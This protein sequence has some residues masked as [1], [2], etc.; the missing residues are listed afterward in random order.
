MEP[1]GEPLLLFKGSL[2]TGAQHLHPPGARACR[3]SIR[4][5]RGLFV[6]DNLLQPGPLHPSVVSLRNSLAGAA[7]KAQ[8]SIVL[9]TKASRWVLQGAPHPPPPPRVHPALPPTGASQ[10]AAAWAGLQ[11]LPCGVG[12]QGCGW[13]AAVWKLNLTPE[14]HSLRPCFPSH[15]PAYWS[16]HPAPPS[17]PPTL[18]TILLPPPTP[19]HPTS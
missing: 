15:A 7:M 19:S 10:H 4:S 17:P 12:S 11:Y 8:T 2:S 9:D 6:S 3:V 5:G 1:A 13:L 18:L 14:L 16:H